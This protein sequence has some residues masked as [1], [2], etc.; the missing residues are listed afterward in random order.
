[1]PQSVILISDV[2]G[3]GQVGDHKKVKDG[4]ARNYLIPQ[5]L[6]IFAT[7][8]ALKK[9]ERQKEKLA[10]ERDRQ[11]AS[12][13]KVAEKLSHVGLEFERPMGQGGRL[14]GSV[15]HLD[16]ASQLAAQGASVEKRSVLMDGPIKLAG[17]H[18]VRVRVHSQVIVDIPVK[19]KGI[20][21]KK[22]KGHRE[23]E[24]EEEKE[25]VEQTKEPKET[26]KKSKEKEEE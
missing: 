25:K 16:I 17:D 8:D 6:A 5:H 3:L 18:K 10:A 15:T 20:E 7:P 12:A 26:D 2:P 19:V 13:Q 22:T 9:V 11:L 23:W 1:M 4:F 24:E 21:E 14:F